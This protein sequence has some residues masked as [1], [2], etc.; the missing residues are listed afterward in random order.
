MINVNEDTRE[1]VVELIMSFGNKR[2]AYAVFGFGEL[3]EYMDGYVYPREVYL[4]VFDSLV[5]GGVISQGSPPKFRP[6]TNEV[7][8]Y[9]K[10]RGYFFSETK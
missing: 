4:P 7:I 2:K 8:G 1:K 3:I 6:G 10:E 9:E 5:D